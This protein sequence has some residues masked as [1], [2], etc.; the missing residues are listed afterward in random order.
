MDNDKMNKDNALFIRGISQDISAIV[1]KLDAF[2]DGNLQKS[3][4]E[5]CTFRNNGSEIPFEDLNYTGIYMIEIKNNLG[6]KSFNSWLEQF[7]ILWE[8]KPYHRRFTPRIINKRVWAQSQ[9]EEHDEWIP[10]Y[11]GVSRK[12][13]ER[14]SGHINLGLDSH[15]FAL[16]LKAREN[17]NNELFR[18]KTIEMCIV[19]NTYDWILPRMERVL[20]DRINPII[21]KQ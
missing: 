17:L 13:S 2:A 5:I 4:Q 15:T 8:A 10:M 6:P 14:I 7:K 20:R 9:V 19:V 3:F 1:T 18:L 16:K 11:L 21:G 12:I